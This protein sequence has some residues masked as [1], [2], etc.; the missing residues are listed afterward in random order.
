[1]KQYH[2]LLFDVFDLSPALFTERELKLPPD[3]TTLF[4]G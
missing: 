3:F 1:M 4:L 2:D